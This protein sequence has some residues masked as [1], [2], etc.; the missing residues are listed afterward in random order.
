MAAEPG[1]AMPSASASAFMVLAVPMVLQWPTEGVLVFTCG[2]A[3]SNKTGKGKFSLQ[4][5]EN[6][7]P[8]AIIST[9]LSSS[10]SP[11][12]CMS[13]AFH[14]IVPDPILSPEPKRRPLSIGPTLRQMAG[15]FYELDISES[16]KLHDTQRRDTHD[17]CRG[18]QEGRCRLVTTSE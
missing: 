12:A 10:I 7:Y 13:L 3:E 15:M 2:S 5:F 17:S 16:C 6:T 11:A 14:K 18:H 4:D 8:A 1:R 9:S